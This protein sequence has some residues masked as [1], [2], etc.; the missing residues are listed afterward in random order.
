MITKKPVIIEICGMP[1]AGKS[2]IFHLMQSELPDV[3][4]GCRVSIFDNWL[5]ITLETFRVLPLYL[6]L[7]VGGLFLYRLKLLLFLRTLYRIVRSRSQSRTRHM[8]F[9]QGPAFLQVFLL[10]VASSFR[11]KEC[12]KSW[13]AMDIS[14]WSNLLNGI[15]WLD[16]DDSVLL[17]R[18]R[19]RNKH[20]SL[21]TRTAAERREFT[22]GFR[23]A[24][25]W[26][27]SIYEEAGIPVL[28]VSTEEN[29]VDVVKDRIIQFMFS[30]DSPDLNDIDKHT[31]CESR[32]VTDSGGA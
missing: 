8:V 19:Q 26:V 31:D 22:E 32:V 10:A 25:D 14:R 23:F 28:R 17:E 11:P 20:H 7:G 16:A 6:K 21:K 15:V 29:N 2:T 4:F 13:I 1:G 5:T 9:D 24:Y 12:L 30:L 18:V 27:L 3:A